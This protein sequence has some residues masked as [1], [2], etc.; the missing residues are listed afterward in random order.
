[1]DDEDS[2]C[3]LMDQYFEELLS[4]YPKERIIFNE[5]ETADFYVTRRG[6][7]KKFDKKPITYSQRK[8][9]RYANE[10]VKEYLKDCHI[11]EFTDYVLADEKNKWG[12]QT[13]FCARVL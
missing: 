6:Y 1:M 5:V 12:K 13:S 7:I 4:L 3:A 11:I 9:I 2:V 8:R 10:K